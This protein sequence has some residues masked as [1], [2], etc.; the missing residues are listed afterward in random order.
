MGT[1]G[2]LFRRWAGCWIDF[3]ALAALFLGPPILVPD[4]V[5]DLAIYVSIFLAVA[6]FPVTEGLWGRSLGK[7]VT[8]TVVVDRNGHKPGFGKAIVRTLTRLIEVNPFLAGGIPAGLIALFTQSHR[9]LGDIL[10]GTYVVPTKLLQAAHE[11]VS[12]R[13][14][15]VFD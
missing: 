15:E 14:A 4:S 6:Y 2:I 3:V 10:A 8:G 12:R 9:R 13:A 1:G 7:L 11:K 5:Q